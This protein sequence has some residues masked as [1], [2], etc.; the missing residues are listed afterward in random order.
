MVDFVEYVVSELKSKRLGKAGALELIRQFSGRRTESGQLHPLVHR[1]V[2]T[3]TQQRY[4]THLRGGEFFLRDHR[5]RMPSGAAVGVLPGVAYLEMARAAVVDAV[6][7]LADG[8]LLA[9]ENVLWLSPFAVE[10]ER[11]ILIDID[12]GDDCLEFRVFSESEAGQRSEHA[13]GRVRFY[14]AVDAAPLDLA[15]MRAAMTRDQWDADTVY[16]T[17]ARIGIEYGPAHRGIVRLDSGD[18]QVL[19]ELALPEVLAGQDNAAYVLHP[20][21]IDSALQAAIGLGERG[22]VPGDPMLPF[23]LESLCI[24]GDCGARPCVFVRHADA[25]STDTAQLTLDLDLCD[26]H[27]NLCVQMRGFSARRF[28]VRSASAAVDAAAVETLVAVPGWGAPLPSPERAGAADF[29]HVRVL[30]CELPGRDALAAKWAGAEIETLTATGR[31]H[32]AQVYE[33]IALQVFERLQDLQKRQGGDRTLLQCVIADSAEGRLLAGLGGMLRT[34]TLEHPSLATQLVLVDPQATPERIAA[35]LADAA[36]RSHIA[37]LRCAA[38]GCRAQAWTVQPAMPDIHNDTGTGESPYREHGVYLIT[39]GL[40]GLGALFAREILAQAEG[41]QVVLTGRSADDEAVRTRLASAFD[42]HAALDRVHY[43]R[44]D[45]DD[46][47]QCAQVVEAIGREFGAIRGVLHCAGTRSDDVILRKTLQDAATV[48]A[49]KV[50]GTWHLDEATRSLDLDFFALFSSGVAAFGNVGQADYAAANGFLDA[51][52]AFRDAR[53]AAG[54]RSGRTVSIDWPLWDEGGMRPDPEAVRWLQTQTGMVPMRSTSGL[55]VFRRALASP[56]AQLFAI[57]GDG[58]RLRRLFDAPA[59]PQPRATTPAPAAVRDASQAIATESHAT[60]AAPTGDLLS[61]ARDFL[62]RE[63]APVLKIAA[64]QIDIQEA[65]ENYGIN[66]ILA[67]NLTAQLE[68]HF[69]PLPKTL[70]FEYQTVAALSEHLVQAHGERLQSLLAPAAA[71]PSAPASPRPAPAAEPAAPRPASRPALRGKATVPGALARRGPA[72]PSM[73]SEPIAIIGLSGRYPEAET[74]REFW[75]NLHDGRDCV[76][77]I[78][79]ER[80]RWQDYYTS[81]REQPG[82]YSKWGGFI[83]GADEF[84]PQFFNISPREAPYIDPQERLFLQHAW[85]A[86]EDAG[87]SRKGLRLP[88]ASGLPGQV[89]VYTGVMYGEYNRSGSL[90]SIANRVS[91]A[92]NVHGPSMTLDTM[93]SSSLTAI[94]LACQDLR[95]G[96]TDMALAGGVNLSI[97][98]DKYS[99]LSAGQFISSDGHCQSFGEGGDGYIPG[100]GVGVVVLKRL[101]DAERDGDAIHAIIRGSALNHGGKTNGYTVPNPQAQAAVIADA[102]RDAGADARHVS[103]IEAHGTGT[104]LGDPIEIAALSKAFREHTQDTGFCLIGS[105]KSNIGHCESAAGIAGLTKVV[106]QMRHRQIVPSLHSARLN[107]NIDFGITPFEVNQRLRDWD[108]PVVDGKRVPRIAGLSSFGAG[109]ANAHFVIEE[110]VAPEAQVQD[111]L[112]AIVPLSARTPD[113]L[114]QKVRDLLFMLQDASDAARRI[115]LASLAYTLQV[116]REPMEERLAFV[117]DSTAHLQDVLSAH[118]D[119]DATGAYRGQVKANKE[120]LALFVA[121]DDYEAVLDKWIGQRKL[122]RLAELWSK[123]LD[124]DWRK[125]HGKHP[126]R[127]MHLPTYPFAKDKYWIEPTVGLFAH[128]GPKP[129]LPR[130]ASLHPLL[131]ENTSDLDQ[132]RFSS[133]FPASSATTVGDAALSSSL[134]LEMARAALA[135]ARREVPA[136]TAVELGALRFGAPFLADGVRPLHIALYPSD[137]GG[138]DFDLYSDDDCVHAQGSGELAPAGIDER[139]DLAALAARMSESAWPTTH[140]SDR[141]APADWRLWHGAGEWLIAAA[142]ARPAPATGLQL[143]PAFADRVFDALAPL[144]GLDRLVPR[145]LAS[146]SVLSA[147]AS[148]MWVWARRSAGDTPAIDMDWCDAHGVV[149]LR[150]RGFVPAGAVDAVAQPAAAMSP[151]L[152]PPAPIAPVP[153]LDAPRLA[154][155]D[156]IALAAPG[157]VPVVIGRHQPKPNASR[158]AALDATTAMPASPA[159]L[160]PMLPAPTPLPIHA[161]VA[162]AAPSATAVDDRID[163]RG[164]LKRSLAQALYLDEANIDDDRPFVD[165]GLDS[166]VGVE[167]VKSI[168]KGLGL[169][170]GA[171]RVYDYANLAALSVYVESQLPKGSAA[172]GVAKSSLPEPAPRNPVPATASVPSVVLDLPAFERPAFDPAAALAS[173][174]QR[175]L[176]T[177][178]S[179]QPELRS[180]LAQALYLDEAA[181]DI[182]SAFVDLGLDSIVG[183][184]WVKTINK[185]YGLEI[186]ATRVYDYANLRAL[187]RF[188]HEEIAKLPADRVPQP[189]LASAPAPVATAPVAMAASQ[190]AAMAAPMPASPPLPGFAPTLPFAQNALRRR[191]RSLPAATAAAS[192]QPSQG[193]GRIAEKIAIVGMSGRYPG[194]ENL[195]QFW[196]NLVEGRN[197]IREIPPSRW[198]VSAYYD[199]S[200]GK[201]GKVY[202]KWLGMLD[203]AEEFDPMFFQISPSEA[204]VMDPQHRLFMQESYRA[205]QDAGY[206]SAA[207]SN[208]KCGVYLGIMSSEYSILLAK[209]SP[210]N[211]ETTANSFAIGAAR[212]AYHLNLKGPAIPVDTACSSSLVAIHLA[213]QALLNHEIDMGLAGGVSLYLIPESYLGMC[214]A[215][216]LSRD[217]QCKTFDNSADGF[218]PGEGVG[219]VVLKRL[220]DAER[221]G[222]EIYGVIIGSGINQDGKTNGITAPSVNSQIDLLRDVYRRYDIDATTINYVE[223]HGTG[224]KLGD[225]IELEALSTVFKEQGG[226]RNGCALGAV[227][228]NLGHTSGAAGVAG[229]HKVLLS[230]RNGMLAP[231]VNLR[232][233]N[234]LFDFGASPFYVSRE[235]HAWAPAFGRKR[236]AAVSA[237]GFSGTNAHVVIEEYVP[238]L[239]RAASGPQPCVVPLSARTAEQLRTMAHDLLDFLERAGT[240]IELRDLAWTLQV[241]RDPMRERAAWVASSVVELQS[242]LR[243]FL[244]GLPVGQRGSVTRSQDTTIP[245][246]EAAALRRRE[247]AVQSAALAALW[248]EGAEIDWAAYH[249]DAQP[250]RLHR[251]PGY[252]FAKERYWPQPAAAAPGAEQPVV[253][254]IDP[255]ETRRPTYYAPAWRPAALPA[256]RGAI[257]ADDV[258]LILDIDDRLFEQI[259]A[260]LLPASPLKAIVLARLDEGDFVQEGPDRFVL[261]ASQPGHFESLLDA[262]RRA[263]LAPSHVIHNADAARLPENADASAAERALRLGVDALF[264]LCRALAAAGARQAPCALVS[265]FHADDG[266]NLAACEALAAFYRSLALENSRYQGRVLALEHGADG[267]AD[268]GID[269]ETLAIDTVTAIV[270]ELLAPSRHEVEVRRRAGE[271]VRAMRRVRA[272]V[273]QALA[274]SSTGDLPLKHGGVYLITGGLGG[275]GLLFA[276]HL[277]EHYRARLVL[278][279]RS[280]LDAVGEQKLQELHALG[281]EAIYLQADVAD[282]DRARALVAGAKARFAALNGVIHSAGVNDDALLIRK[283][284]ERFR[285]VL[286]PKVQGTLHLDRFTADEPLDLFVLFS[287]GAGSFGN[288]GQTDYAYANAFMDAFA[289]HRERA[290]ARRQRYGRTLSIG[291]PY[292]LAGGMQVSADDLQR[293][294]ARTGL[295][296]LPTEIGIAYWETLLRSDLPRA[297]ALYG[298]PSK[299]AAH[300]D[301]AGPIGNNAAAAPAAAQ[302]VADAS[303]VALPDRDALL[304]QARQYVCELVHTETRIPVDR[305]DIDERFEAF[306]FDSIMIGRLNATLEQDLGDLPKTLMYEYDSVA[307]LAA[308]L[309]DHATATLARRLGVAP[310][311]TEAKT[312]APPVS[313][314]EAPTAPVAMAAR[315]PVAVAEAMPAQAEP[316]AIIGVHAQ[317]PQSDDLDTFWEHLRTGADLIQLVPANRWNYAEFHDPDPANAEHGKIYCKWGGFIED[318]DKFDAGFFNIA[319]AEAA[320]ID[321][322]ERRF[323]QSAWSAIED[324]GYTRERLKQRYPKGKSAD[325]GVFVGVTTNTYQLLA[326]EAWQRG[327][328]VTP[329]GMPWS[330]ANRVSYA[331]DL[332][333]PSMPVD[334]AC[335]S[336]LVAVHLACESLRR[337]ECQVALAGGV[338]LYLHPAKY[339]SFCHRRMLAVGDKCRSYGDGDDGFIPGEGVGTLVLK[340]LRQAERDG[341][342]IYGVI[343]GSAYDHSGRSNGYATPNPNAQAQVIAQA[344]AQADVPARSIGYIEGHGTGTR[345]GDSLEVAAITQAFAQQTSETGF[346]ALASLKANI[347]HAESAT[348]IAGIARILMQFRHR[349]IAP[350]IHAD[351]V[352]PDI[353]FARAPC[354]LQT[355]LTPWESP[356]GLPRRALI[357]AFGAGGV[358]AC[359]VLEEYLPADRQATSSPAGGE[360]L[361]VLS[362]MNAERLREYAWRHVDFLALNPDCD[363]HALC[364][365][366]QIGREAMPERLALVV[367]SAQQLRQT[368]QRWLD[369][370]PALVAGRDRLWQGRL[371]PRSGAGHA[372]REQR[373]RMQAL[374]DLRDLAGLAA[375]WTE[376]GKVDW[377]RLGDAAVQSIVAAPVYP[378][379][380]ERHWVVD[381]ATAERASV[382]TAPA[383]LHPL[384]SHNV[385]TLDGIRFAAALDGD[386]YYARD[387]RIQGQAVFP[388][389][390]FL[391]MACVAASIAGQR[392]V[393]RLRDIYWV[394]P[395]SLTDPQQDLKI[396]LRSKSGVALGGAEFAITTVDDDQETVVHCEGR[397]LFD[398]GGAC[399]DPVEAAARPSLSE[400]RQRCGESHGSERYYRLFQSLGFDYGPTFRVIDSVAIGDGCAMARLSLD[401]SLS[402]DFEQY[403]LH[404]TLVDGALQT[405]IALLASDEGGVPHLPFA[406][407]EIEIV[408]SLTPQCH[409]LVERVGDAQGS[410]GILQFN[411]HILSESGELL[412]KISHFYVRALVPPAPSPGDAASD[413]SRDALAVNP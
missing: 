182:D 94:H 124:L 184:E 367:G 342:R 197:S 75:R 16:A 294:E 285:R 352:N 159:P 381:F 264:G 117:V 400:W 86:I 216:M 7:E 80:W 200:P 59:A 105:A 290:R 187:A 314:V 358:N 147:C 74:L 210:L 387:H 134:L 323:L 410:A 183:V 271:G 201:P 101:S 386:R 141:R 305:I 13:S 339:Q 350:S 281:A 222:D 413:R 237:F 205:F 349:Q 165:L 258:L 22:L 132:L 262:L 21:L 54:E 296:A 103:Y 51:F 140:G 320:I 25:A 375:F 88:R 149:A 18:G 130:A 110:Y 155:P 10:T 348:S 317:F 19:G 128:I 292:W 412:V 315:P 151:A 260:R 194:A 371:D 126:P 309:V 89:G 8:A 191:S 181:I 310:G 111:G 156:A 5:V 257:A 71:T 114:M 399:H 354:Y 404:P 163:V 107:P 284:R 81:D 190:P 20:S 96:R 47:A 57:E 58:R 308:Y 242:Q 366:L 153:V 172:P 93:C 167:W 44:L 207:L 327:R 53:V 122:P 77:E 186:S 256:R 135:C 389:A 291:W 85:M 333:G 215:G 72:G 82:H 118:I 357:N 83:S 275:L 351:T 220:S 298:Q 295:S 225:P 240:D 390:G 238:T 97:H 329:S 60:S 95:L 385:S 267:D 244:A 368:L 408:G 279:G 402:K 409:V 406:I 180:S 169:E 120:M 121:D 251:V 239:H 70:F 289:E 304:A 12:A 338:N 32:A 131:H 211:V 15:A 66:S 119:G 297:L 69:G 115:D 208:R 6:P 231:N 56:H 365:T 391:E 383:R 28:D 49:P 378:F 2:S 248:V 265:S 332:Q 353:D 209:G 52:A 87:Y 293:T 286:G 273:E 344:L 176:P 306:G 302:S 347:G 241:G 226:K 259:R 129:A 161:P 106:L 196:R 360:A 170:I 272:L 232:Q 261:D 356:A 30:L 39:G 203:G 145:D 148:P 133:V 311:S 219:T 307:D 45:L 29:A 363:V 195:E 247:G 99:M 100:E 178:E 76:V 359:A 249:L 227:K 1:N 274:A 376:G 116:G 198:D 401:P 9:F 245:T 397:A 125:F 340:P 154:K 229:V 382:A 202:C 173:T 112:P 228:T 263:G 331:L 78:P 90:A 146:L 104:K 177:V 11:E 218:V 355:S 136:A 407:D 334:T 91:Y 152:M 166:I 336:S 109:G 313:A 50:R 84:D 236:R 79:A 277:A 23:A 303:D 34:A 379:A 162:T 26:E 41:A 282:A 380:R 189:M 171:T 46:A 17:Y 392:R 139:L 396:G 204:E 370:D 144:L 62:R 243:D 316:I 92:L 14:D 142:D 137:T 217:G 341:D 192:A 300:C 234:A 312:V 67:M 268:A 143:D 31:E 73:T 266:A 113:Q 254:S 40:G 24:L 345:M 373:E 230:L 108:T 330:I 322:Q 328:M 157:T 179:L 224:T 246:E 335:S 270:E 4:R 369:G 27:G 160:Q 37:Q 326:P 223:T 164:F 253:A 287:S 35:D 361:F 158:L 337:R 280:A 42:G 283:D 55:A 65:L 319:D 411:L 123:G 321:P 255:V 405:V 150:W 175:S 33:S 362:A 301:P 63:F 174:A 377:A 43:R 193:A 394:Q 199:P 398:E 102:L 278:S 250:R 388:G 252:P 393:R 64:N 235:P 372:S 318:F 269:L 325:V 374:C 403:V 213:C 188:V 276:R 395:L 299:I 38:D 324:A 68:K 221:D 343:R 214:R 127:R 98:P 48:L 168:N 36:A 233:E 138:I 212:I 185:T 346:C 384:I 206:S 61:Q 3:L 288:V 364:R